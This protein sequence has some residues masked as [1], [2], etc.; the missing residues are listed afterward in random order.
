MLSDKKITMKNIAVFVLPM[1]L[2]SY[3]AI[4]L[5]RERASVFPD[6]KSAYLGQ[7]PP[8]YDAGNFCAGD[9]E[10]IGMGGKR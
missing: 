6:Q 8:G 9:D 2:V 1:L 4:S 10:R 7:K 3:A 5:V